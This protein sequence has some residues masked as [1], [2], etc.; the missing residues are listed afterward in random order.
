MGRWI[1]HFDFMATQPFPG[2]ITSLV[3]QAK[4]RRGM[5][6][7]VNVFIDEKFSFAV[8]ILVIEKFRLARGMAVDAA[9]LTELLR[10]DGDTKAYAKAIFFLGYRARSEAEVRE[11]L[12]RDEWPD[13]VIERVLQKLREQGFLNDEN[14][15]NLWV[16][17]RSHS[18]PRGG[19]ML[20]QELR[21][22]GVDKETIAAA[23]PG[24]EEES[25]NALAALKTKL[26]L[27]EKFDEKTA[28]EKGI[29]FLMRRGFNYGVAKT[30]WDQSHEEDEES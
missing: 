23:L 20:Q 16:E 3:A 30:A 10:Y 25:E 24:A 5:G 27:W 8:S 28:R 11:R 13:E 22:K 15:S 7:R 21:Q 2:T 9:F 12:K 26:R 18:R 19:R 4:K 17:N 29:G 6:T 14:F 1:F